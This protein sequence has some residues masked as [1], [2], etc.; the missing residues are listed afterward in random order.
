MVELSRRAAL[1]LLGLGIAGTAISW[2]R[3]TGADIPG[4]G[5]DALTVALFGTAQ[6]AAARQSLVEGFQ[7]LHPGI[8][9]R[10]V[11]VQGQDWSNFFAKILTMVAAGNPP[12][13]VSV[14]TEGTQ[15]FAERLAHPIDDYVQRDAAD[16][17][18]YFDDVHPSLIES[19]MYKGSLF[20]L[21]DNFNAANVY[22]NTAAFERAGLERPRDDWTVDDF[23][24]VARTMK[25]SAEGSFL[26]Y[27]WNNRL[28]GGVVPWL[29]VNDASFLTE[30]K[31]PGGDW[32]WSR[33][34]PGEAP[35]G[36]GYL[37][38]NADALNE[39]TIESF[40]VLQRM[41]GEGIA[42]NPAQGGGNELVSLFAR[43]SVGMTPA[44]G[45]WVQGLHDAGFANDEYDVTYFPR[46][47]SQRHQF[48]AG[49]YA[50]MQTSP[51]KDEAWEW[52]KYCISTEGM[53]LAHQKPDSSLPRRT[54][55]AEL[56]G[57]E[58]GPKHWE[59]FYDTLDRHP[60][61]GPMPAPPQQ[62]AVE[63]ALIKNVVST[64]T[65]GPGGVR[66]GL[67]TMQRDLELALKG[68]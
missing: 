7:R 60:D 49:G 40:E 28:W 26:P 58:I 35:R 41:V 6:D 31:A 46:M 2:P 47:R 44:G 37:W 45:F 5:D 34:Y 39:R 22:Y 9:V 59:V 67:E 43:G 17:Q 13:V 8:T 68:R 16:L 15:L 23:F 65:N 19:F 14:A 20:Q 61:T 63:S 66:R 1:A 42:A 54:L 57:G 11:A 24:T 3:L 55:N 25:D 4:R 51:R 52:L 64:I 27:F 48:G 10:I 62:A 18:E 29:Y 21:P 53:A 38:Q 12:D 36:G 32:L 50:I 30:E 56:Y 33:F